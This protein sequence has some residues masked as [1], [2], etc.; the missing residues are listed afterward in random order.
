MQEDVNRLQMLVFSDRRCCRSK[1]LQSSRTTCAARRQPQSQ[2]HCSVWTEGGR[3]SR[4]DACPGLQQAA[5]QPICMLE[6]CH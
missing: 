4:A 6:Q 5:D 2:A 1:K 3:R